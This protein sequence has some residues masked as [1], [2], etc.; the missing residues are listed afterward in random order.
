M[1]LGDNYSV[2]SRT[3]KNAFLFLFFSFHLI[4]GGQLN[5]AA[6]NLY[7]FISISWTVKHL[8][9]FL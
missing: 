8:H 7:S 3:V 5:W 1:T 2:W 4:L 9:S 6:K